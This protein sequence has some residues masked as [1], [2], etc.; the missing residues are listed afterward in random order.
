MDMNYHGSA[1][2]SALS[3]VLLVA[4]G[5]VY[6]AST[7][8]TAPAA[9]KSAAAVV[10]AAAAS[11]WSAHVDSIRGAFSGIGKPGDSS[12]LSSF[13]YG[14]PTVLSPASAVNSVRAGGAGTG[15]LVVR[16]IKPVDDATPTL[17]ADWTVN[18]TIPRVEIQFFGTQL[19]IATQ[20]R[21]YLLTAVRVFQVRH[22]TQP[23]PAGGTKE[24]E[25]LL[26]GFQKLTLC[27][28]VGCATEYAAIDVLP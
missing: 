7:A 3:L 12:E 8:S 17:F 19:G 14:A 10:P 23:D 28:G 5:A 2:A 9:S 25:E 18:G 1:S 27:G 4:A 15:T 16:I 26:L 22:F 13:E 21:G 20:L 11:T 24:L 6:A